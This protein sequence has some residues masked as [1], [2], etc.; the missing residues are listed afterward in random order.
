MRE[1]QCESE[2]RRQD[3]PSGIHTH[4]LHLRNVST[5][6]E[7]VGHPDT[8]QSWWHRTKGIRHRCWKQTIAMLAR[9]MWH[10]GTGRQSMG[11]TKVLLQPLSDAPFHSLE[12]FHSSTLMQ[13]ESL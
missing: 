2:Q 3:N 9:K 10:H 8:L 11:W 4:S 7:E 1:F 13:K 6:W 12:L 5:S